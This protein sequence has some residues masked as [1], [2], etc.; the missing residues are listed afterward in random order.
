VGHPLLIFAACGAAGA[1]I[2]SF[3]LYLKSV[4]QEPPLKMALIKCLFS[5][6]VGSICAV[7]F[8]RLI[9]QNFPWTVKP[10][11]W[12]LALVIGLSSNRLVPVILKKVDGWAEAFEGKSR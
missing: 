12:P 5:I 2:Y 8:T 9:G 11:P 6:F 7:V 1:L 4:T 3:P 10:E